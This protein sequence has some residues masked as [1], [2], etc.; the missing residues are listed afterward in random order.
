MSIRRSIVST[1]LIIIVFNSRAEAFLPTADPRALSTILNEEIQVTIK[2]AR[3]HGDFQARLSGRME[4]ISIR[5]QGETYRWM[6]MNSDVGTVQAWGSPLIQLEPGASLQD[7]DQMLRYFVEENR[8]LFRV[9]SNELLLDKNRT[10][11]S[12]VYKYITYKRF[13]YIEGQPYGV[14][15]AFIT[16]RFKADRLIEFTNYSFGEIGPEEMPRTSEEDALQAATE[17][18]SMN[19]QPGSIN[20]KVVTELQPFYSPEG[21]MQWRLVY[22]V[23]IKRNAGEGTWKYSVSARDGRI[24]RLMSNLHSAGNIAA[25]VLQRKPGDDI[26]QVPLAEAN[27]R[28]IGGKNVER[29]QLDGSFQMEAE[30]ASADLAGLR[31]IIKMNGARSVSQAIP[32]D[33]QLMFS[34]SQ[35]LS[36]SMAYYFVN[37][38]NQIAR[39]FIKS[40]PRDTQNGVKDFLNTPLT[41]NTRVKHPIIKGC[42]AWFDTEEKTLNFL[43]ADQKCEASSH[44]ADVI[45]HEWGHGLDDALGGIQ[46]GAFSEGVGDI[47]SFLMTGDPKL[48]PGFVK[49]SDKPIRSVEVIKTYPKDRSRDPH[50]EGLIIAGAW[51]EAMR[52]MQ[53]TYGE[54]E[55]RSKTAEIFFKHLVSTDSY[56][57]SYMGA[58]TVDDDDGNLNN[59]TPHMCLLNSAFA[60]RGIA[61][62]DP[63]CAGSI[64]SLPACA[65]STIRTQEVDVSAEPSFDWDI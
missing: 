22:Q 48:A 43:E 33:G 62:A 59:C 23:E 40:A 11:F 32:A 10:K 4:E 61:Q 46:D 52:N 41:V 13:H 34:S 64:S 45:Y 47:V 18:M 39:M 60:R 37:R 35:F 1:I 9:R 57:D 63:R 50:Q 29:T 5:N 53:K 44:F 12:G 7:I 24:V 54:E 30:G 20:R 19:E 42:N 14:E 56:L 8:N 26:V 58:L 2:D 31:A 21:K 6:G 55:G 28:G 3:T 65:E 25:E 49:G 17:D 15:G 38:V 27:V 51:Y 16:F 36:E